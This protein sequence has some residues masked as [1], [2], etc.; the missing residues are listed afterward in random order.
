MTI[1]D[2]FCETFKTKA[3]CTGAMAGMIAC[4]PLPLGV[5]ENDPRVQQIVRW[6]KENAEGDGT[7]PNQMGPWT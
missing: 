3:D 2:D 5:D 1:T 7:H 4:C 6:C